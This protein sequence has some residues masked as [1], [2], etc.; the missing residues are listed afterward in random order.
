MKL[1][2]ALNQI[3]DDQI[4]SMIKKVKSKIHTREAAQVE[5]TREVTM[6]IVKARKAKE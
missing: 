3:T 6:A 2:E 5:L 1:E 4:D